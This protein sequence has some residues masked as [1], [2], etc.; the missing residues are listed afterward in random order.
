[1]KSTD[2]WQELGP[3]REKEIK[4][5]RTLLIT[6]VI[7]ATFLYGVGFTFLILNEGGLALT[8]VLCGAVL[9]FV[10]ESKNDH[11]RKKYRAQRKAIKRRW[12]KEIEKET[13]NA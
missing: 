2:I 4:E 10:A 12:W 7:S 8:F 5:R 9:I 3:L 11:I 13:K 1:M 6:L